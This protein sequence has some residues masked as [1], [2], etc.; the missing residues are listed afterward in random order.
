M[1]ACKYYNKYYSMPIP[2]IVTVYY[3]FMQKY[4]VILYYTL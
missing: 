3:S 1:C 4:V 2:F